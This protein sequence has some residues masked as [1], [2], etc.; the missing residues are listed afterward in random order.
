MKLKKNIQHC[1]RYKR[2]TKVTD[3][4][5]RVVMMCVHCSLLSHTSKLPK[6]IT[7]IALF[8]ARERGY[9]PR[10]GARLDPSIYIGYP[11]DWPRVI[12]LFG[13][14]NEKSD[15]MT[16]GLKTRGNDAFSSS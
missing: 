12:N 3:T 5:M 16:L 6:Y 4:S 1:Y 15:F 9:W 2:R 10:L 7:D 11:I 8:A 14:Q 13:F